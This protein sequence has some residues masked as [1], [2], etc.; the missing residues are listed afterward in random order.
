MDYLNALKWE[1]PE[2]TTA[3]IRKRVSELMADEEVAC[4]WSGKKLM[5]P[6]YAIDHAFPFARWPNND[7][8]NLL[9]TKTQIN[10]KKSDKLPTGLKLSSSRELIVHWWKQGWQHDKNEFFSQAN[11]ALPNLR[12]DNTNFDDV[13][14]AF[15]LQRDR[16]KALQQLE[17]W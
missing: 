16:I 17:D 1:D 4:C 11:L 9:P 12:P 10:A 6:N 8:W 14:E 5:A 13:F 2:R 7:L 3:K 15:M